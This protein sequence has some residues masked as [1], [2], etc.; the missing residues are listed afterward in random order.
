MSKILKLK[1][2]GKDFGY[3]T[4]D[5]EVFYG[6]GSKSDAVKFELEH[7]KDGSDAHYFKIA[8][9]KESYMDVKYSSSRL[10]V[11]KPTFSVGSSSI[12]AWELVG[13]ELRM[14]IKKK[15]TGKCLSRSTSDLRS[16]ALYGNLTGHH[17]DV[18]IEDA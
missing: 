7:Y 9:T 13:G 11:V 14:I 8:G 1:D 16:E 6:N 17:C 4:L 5:G 3:V 15:F 12:C 2:N 18:T 10:Q